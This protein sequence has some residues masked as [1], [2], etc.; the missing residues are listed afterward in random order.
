[1]ELSRLPVAP[2][3]RPV[4]NPQRSVRQQAVTPGAGPVR[5]P[6]AREAA[7]APVVQ[8]EL[9]ARP[10]SLFQST[11]AFLAERSLARARPT[12]QP[13][14]P[15]PVSRAAIGSYLGNDRRPPPSPGHSLD[16]VV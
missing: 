8:G 5:A 13:H 9:L 4:S 2:L 3:G 16:F 7:A 1:M 10:R 11:S 14:H 12:E 6:A 15:P